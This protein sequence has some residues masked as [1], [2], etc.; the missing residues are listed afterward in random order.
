MT[1][2]SRPR[3]RRKARERPPRLPSPDWGRIGA[4]ALALAGIV[5]VALAIRWI[6][7]QPI[8]RV[9]VS[10]PFQRVSPD[11]VER[12][13][14][15]S[16]RGVGLVSIELEAMRRALAELPWVDAVSVQRR[17]PRGLAVTVVEQ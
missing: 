3:N 8:E 17:W 7:D 2:W 9:A 5:A 16:A 13:V 10:G 14:R 11:E 6:L 1:R 15:S 12:A 4:N